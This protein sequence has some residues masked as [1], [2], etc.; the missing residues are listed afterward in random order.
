MKPFKNIMFRVSALLLFLSPFSLFAQVSGNQ[1]FSMLAYQP[2]ARIAALGG[3]GISVYEKDINLAIQNPALLRAHQS[4]QIGFS[5]GFYFADV[6]AGSL[7]SAYA[8][9]SNQTFGISM[10]Y[11]S[12]GNF[13][14]TSANGEVL[15]KFTVGDYALGMLYSRRLSSRLQIGTQL[16]V[17]YSSLADYS[18]F[19][20][21]MDV[22]LT[23]HDPVELW[24][25][26]IVLS[27][28]GKQLKSYSG[29]N[30]EDMPLNLQAGVSKKLKNAPFR[31]SI[32]SQH[33]EKPGKLLYQNVNKPS[34][35]KDLSTGEVI[36]ENI[37]LGN[38][39]MSHMV[40]GTELLLGKSLYLAFGYNY[41]RRWEMGLKDLAGSAGFSW[42]FG[43][44][45]SRLSFAYGRATTLTSNATDHL[46]LILNLQSAAKK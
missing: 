46:S 30:S 6:Q 28:L 24:T 45:V 39:V 26:S 12:Y 3:Y 37:N 5:H 29:T 18:S 11:V 2:G 17:A 22:G 14:K 32:T 34:L 33:L 27:N 38:K 25:Y 41:L 43:I 40:L 10:Q 21:A 44:R 7:I 20:L 4:R 1:T 36:P 19:G 15:G 16:K 42:G 23:Y 13:E 9:D 31:F 35:Q 8:P